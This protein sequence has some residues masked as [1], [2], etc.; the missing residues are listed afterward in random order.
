M[1][2]WLKVFE[3]DGRPVDPD[4]TAAILASAP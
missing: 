3:C 4:A 1:R 2:W